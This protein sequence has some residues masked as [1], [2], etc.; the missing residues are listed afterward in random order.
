MWVPSSEGGYASFHF[1]AFAVSYFNA[2]AFD[3]TLDSFA[4]AY[5]YHINEVS[6]FEHLCDVYG[7]SEQGLDVFELLFDVCAVDFDFD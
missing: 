4:L 2:P 5:G 1:A 7:F 6:F 3:Y